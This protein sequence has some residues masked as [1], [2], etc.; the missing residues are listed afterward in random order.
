MTNRIRATLITVSLVLLSYVVVGGLLGK[1]APSS[2][3]EKTYRDLGVYSEVLNRIKQEYVTDP[4][5]KKVTDGAI[6]GLLESL[7]PYSTYLTPEQ[8]QDYLQ[9]PDPGPAEVGIFPLQAH[10]I[11]HRG[12]GTSGEPRRKSRR[13][14]RRSD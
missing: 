8:Y 11:R 5:M 12:G 4:D 9:H 1:G 7:D 14:T 3:S 2:S 13:Q 6:R 10:G